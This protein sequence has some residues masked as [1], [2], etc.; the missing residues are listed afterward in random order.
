MTPAQKTPADSEIL[1][2]AAAQ[3]VTLVEGGDWRTLFDGKSLTGWRVTDFDE[4]GKVELKEGL[5]VLTKGAP[6]VGVNY[7]NETPKLN[8]EVT[9][10][11][12]RVSGSDFFCGFTFPVRDTFCSFIVGGWGGS[13]VGLSN[14]DGSDASENET[15]QFINFENGRW[16][17]IRLRVSDRRIEA[18]IEQKKV[19]DVLTANR[20]IELRFGEIELSK[21]FGLSAWSTSAAYRQIKIQNVTG[22]ADVRN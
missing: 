5:L 16:Y 13:L 15:T 1:A 18:W 6:F 9:L 4:G 12:M 11:A 3:P 17:R 22:P 8:Y 10:E 14:I 20:K 7:T 21:P 2:R 19:V